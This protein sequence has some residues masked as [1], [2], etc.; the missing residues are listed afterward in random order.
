MG[1]ALCAV[2]ALASAADSPEAPGELVGQETALA[3]AGLTS[4]RRDGLTGV[5]PGESLRLAR[6]RHRTQ[7]AARKK[8]MDPDSLT[9]TVLVPENAASPIVVFDDNAALKAAIVERGAARH[10]TDEW[11]AAGLY[12]LVDRC[13]SEGFWGVYVGKAPSGVK[14]RIRTHLRN[15]DTWCRALLV[16]RDT[17]HGFNSAQIGWL[18]GRL[19]DLL[20]AS[21]G[22]RLSNKVRPGD[23]TLAPYDR[24][25]LEMVLVSIQRLM[26]LLGHDPSSG[27]DTDTSAGKGSSRRYGVKLAQLLEAGLIKA[28]DVLVSTNGAWSARAR[29]T[30]DA[31]IVMDDELYETPSGAACAAKNGP[32]NGWD[33][34]A[35][36]TPT[37]SV[38]LS[39]LRTELLE[40]STPPTQ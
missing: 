30:S 29:I 11:D 28:D 40:Q 34:W 18:E 35:R 37:G 12:I 38:P 19:Y 1:L 2:A 4:N 9:V 17:T 24:H 32:A 6:Y 36:Q 13:D 8:A 20:K 3:G 14:D 5:R 15:K 33:F 10:L 26:R 25:A 7:S 23:E 39:T 31:R 22:A 27:D 16:Q 21:D